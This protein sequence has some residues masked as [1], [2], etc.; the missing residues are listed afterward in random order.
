MY[1]LLLLLLLVHHPA[2]RSAQ[3]KRNSELTLT[4]FS[5]DFANKCGDKFQ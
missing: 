1:L 2:R 5:D 3:H 4:A